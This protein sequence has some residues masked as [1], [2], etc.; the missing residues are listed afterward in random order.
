MSSRLA[1]VIGSFSAITMLLNCLPRRVATRN[2][3]GG[4]DSSGQRHHAEMAQPVGGQA[5]VHQQARPAVLELIALLPQVGD[6]LVG[7]ADAVDFIAD[8]L[9]VAPGEDQRGADGYILRATITGISHS[10]RVSPGR[11][12]GIS[13][14]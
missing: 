8:V 14:L 4:T 5:A 6:S 2:W 3:P 9:G 13:G 11:G 1:P 10:S 12:P 7:G